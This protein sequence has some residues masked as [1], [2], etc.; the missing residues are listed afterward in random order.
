MDGGGNWAVRAAYARCLPHNAGYIDGANKRRSGFCRAPDLSGPCRR[1]GA[2][3]ADDAS[4]APGWV[5]MG[6]ASCPHPHLRFCVA[7]VFGL[8]VRLMAF[9]PSTLCL[10]SEFFL[11]LSLKKKKKHPSRKNA[12]QICCAW[13]RRSVIR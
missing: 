9:V 5:D 6:R 3:C 12:A 13:G 11:P 1:V 7:D 10:I 4:P 2:T 8:L